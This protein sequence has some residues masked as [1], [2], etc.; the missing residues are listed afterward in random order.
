M[1]SGAELKKSAQ[2]SKIAKATFQNQRDI[3]LAQLRRDPGDKKLQTEVQE[4]EDTLA[5][6]QATLLETVSTMLGVHS[7]E[8]FQFV[9]E[10]IRDDDL[11][12][13]ETI[14]SHQQGTGEAWTM[15]REGLKS[16]DIQLNSLSALQVLSGVEQVLLL[17]QIVGIPADSVPMIRDNW[18]LFLKWFARF[19]PMGDKGLDEAEEERRR[20]REKT[21]KY[22]LLDVEHL[23]VQEESLSLEETLKRIGQIL[24]FKLESDWENESEQRPRIH[25]ARAVK[26]FMLRFVRVK[27]VK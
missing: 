21:K 4:L 26:S 24:D 8:L 6:P 27:A 15:V 18:P 19:G 2:Q 3:K 14:S 25:L 7:I 1:S 12:W 23:D 20:I 10:M 11:V 5:L 9:V 17:A 13:R 16:A 22:S